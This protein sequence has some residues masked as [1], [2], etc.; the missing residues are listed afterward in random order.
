MKKVKLN[1]KNILIASAL[2]IL[3][4]GIICAIQLILIPFVLIL[5]EK[6]A[7]GTTREVDKQHYA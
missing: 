7:S 1:K 6:S 4:I 3:V 2:L 5:L